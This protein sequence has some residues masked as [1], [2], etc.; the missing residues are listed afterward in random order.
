MLEMV[1]AGFSMALMSAI[2]NIGSVI[3]QGS[4]NAL[5]NLYIT[6][7][8]GARRLAELFHTPG[9][10]LGTSVATYT[11]QN[12]GGGNRNRIKKGVW[13]AFFLFAVWWIFSM[14]FVTFFVEDAVRLVTGSSNADI[15]YNY[16]IISQNQ[17]SVDSY[18][19]SDYY[20]EK[21]AAGNES[22]DDAACVQQSGIDRKGNFCYLGRAGIWVFCSVPLRTGHM[23]GLLYF[24]FDLRIFVQ[25]GIEIEA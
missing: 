6:A 12:M 20:F 7:Q 25:E 15:I 24:C 18:D 8:V 16:C 9:L 23:G 22:F 14:V 5:G 11:S 1:V 3:L 2:Y 17:F 19:G 21:Y 13:S 4:I 10:A